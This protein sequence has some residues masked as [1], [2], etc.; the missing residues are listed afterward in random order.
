[1]GRLGISKYPSEIQSKCVDM[2]KKGFSLAECSEK[3]GPYPSIIRDWCIRAGILRTQKEGRLLQFE[4]GKGV[5]EDHYRWSGGK[6]VS[7]AGYVMLHVG[8][9]KKNRAEHLV[10]AE[11]VL[12]RKLKKGECIHHIDG[13]KENNMNNNLL[14]CD[15]SYHQCLHGK[16][17]YLYM[18][19]HFKQNT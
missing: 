10:V 18:R 17:S 8:H 1:M 7:K 3:L 15:L 5:G 14:I 12:G 9:G 4:K 19:E 6:N 11:K 2:Y 13:D 16:M